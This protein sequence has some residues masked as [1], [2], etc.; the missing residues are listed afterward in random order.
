MS[1]PRTRGSAKTR[2]ATSE[3]HASPRWLTWLTRISLVVGLVALAITVWLVGPGTIL[4]HLR[5]IGWFFVILVG[6]EIVSSS[7]DGTAVYFMAHGPGQPRWR[8]AVVA[9]LVGRGINSITPGGHLGEPVKVGLLARHCSPRR[10]VAAVMYAGL[11]DVV[12]SLGVTAAGCMVTTLLFD[13]PR[14]ATLGLYVAAALAAGAA[15]AIVVLLRRGM[16]STLAN[17]LARLRL[18]SRARRDRWNETLE[19]VDARLRGHDDGDQRRK[20]IA[21]VAISQAL[22]KGLGYFT[23]MSAGYVLSPA[24]FVALL[25]AAVVIS[26]VSSIIPMGLGISE[27]GNVALFSLIGAPPALGLALALARRVN[28]IAFASIGFAALLADRLGRRLRGR[29]TGVFPSGKT[30][31]S[32]RP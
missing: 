30:F 2:D 24:Q 1:T 21:C 17:A 7:F 31:G 11:I 22:Q 26:W 12:I 16:L 3:D 29:L 13:L 27:G 20:A 10:V 25:S 23:V 6:L 5:E 28:Q 8:D 14:I 4:H 18:I 9:Q 15:V 19:A 32:A